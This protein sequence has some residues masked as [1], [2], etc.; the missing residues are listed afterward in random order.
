ML[1]KKPNVFELSTHKLH[2]NVQECFKHIPQQEPIYWRE[3]NIGF[4]LLLIMLSK[5]N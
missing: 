2:N 5:L 4:E 1:V 3:H